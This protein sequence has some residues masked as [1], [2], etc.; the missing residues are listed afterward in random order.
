MGN[1]LT[2]GMRD[3]VESYQAVRAV[4]LALPTFLGLWLV[5]LLMPLKGIDRRDPYGGMMYTLYLTA[6]GVA[7]IFALPRK[8]LA[9]SPTFE[10]QFLAVTCMILLAALR[11]YLGK[12][13][14]TF[15]QAD[16]SGDPAVATKEGESN[17]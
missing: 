7:L 17:G 6:S 8:Y 12:D 1:F 9:T 15:E 16:V 3:L 5:M 2:L 13:T 11:W 10:V 4:D 14:L